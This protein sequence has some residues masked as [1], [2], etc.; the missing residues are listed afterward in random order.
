LFTVLLFA[1]P[2]IFLVLELVLHPLR[3]SIVLILGDVCLSLTIFVLLLEL[4]L[5]QLVVL[6]LLGFALLNRFLL[7]LGSIPEPSLRS[8]LFAHVGILR[9][10]SVTKGSISSGHVE[11]WLLSSSVLGLGGTVG[12]LS[13][14]DV[15]L[16]VFNI[17]HL[18]LIAVGLGPVVELDGR[19]SSSGLDSVGAHITLRHLSDGDVLGDIDVVGEVNLGGLTTLVLGLRAEGQSE[20]LVGVGIGASVVFVVHLRAVC[21]LA[22]GA[23]N[24]SIAV[25]LLGVR[26]EEAVVVSG[27]DTLSTSESPVES[28]PVAIV[29]LG[30][31]SSK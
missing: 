20:I 6:Q 31:G 28:N 24:L 30:R 23:N 7:S 19:R 4:G 11:S 1:L 18:E 25:K 8:L 5:L 9:L 27:L 21:I 15:V 12:S 14:V 13:G 10:A 29:P 26:S 16:V 17:L 3:S 2:V 22:A